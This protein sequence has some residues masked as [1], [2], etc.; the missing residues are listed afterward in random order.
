MEVAHSTSPLRNSP[1]RPMSMHETVQLP[2]T[3]SFTPRSRAASMTSRLTGSSTI[4]ASS[5]MRSV[6]AASIQMPS[7]PAARSFPCTAVV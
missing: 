6:E 2:P 4:T 5:S 7:Q 1:P 3:K